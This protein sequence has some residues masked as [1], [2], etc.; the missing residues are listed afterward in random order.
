MEDITIRVGLWF[1]D[2]SKK[3]EDIQFKGRLLAKGQDADGYIHEVPMCQSK[4][5]YHIYLTEDGK[6]LV[7]VYMHTVEYYFPDVAD[8]A[9]VDE[10]PGPKQELTGTVF[11]GP[12]AWVP[13]SVLNKAKRTLATFKEK[14]AKSC[15]L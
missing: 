15:T 5:W 6:Y 10:L 2:G 4:Y 9:V 12:M 13:D 7:R 8:Y 11:G 3:V 14:E 1:K